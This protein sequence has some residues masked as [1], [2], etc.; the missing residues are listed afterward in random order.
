[1]TSIHQSGHFYFDPNDP[2]YQDHFP[3]C[4]VVPGSL[5]VEAFLKVVAQKKIDPTVIRRFRFKR[6][7]IPGTYTYEMVISTGMI[8]CTLLQKEETFATGKILYGR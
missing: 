7:V 6:F 4:P 1:M 8:D 2:I 5:I 3:G